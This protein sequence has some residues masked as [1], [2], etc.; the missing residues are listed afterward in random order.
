MQSSVP[1][2]LAVSTFLLLLLTPGPQGAVQSLQA[3]QEEG[4]E[5]A[6]QAGRGQGSVSSS[7]PAHSAPPWRADW[8]TFLVLLLSPSPQVAEQ[9]DQTE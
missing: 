2:V 9:E 5:G 1:L 4:Q 3:P 6:G 7:E 8:R